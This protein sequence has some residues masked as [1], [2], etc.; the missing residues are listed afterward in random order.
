M[1]DDERAWEV[2][3]RR[4]IACLRS[5]ELVLEAY[6]RRLLDLEEAKGKLMQLG[7]RRWISEEVLEA[8]LKQ[9]KS[10]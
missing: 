2:A 6:R 4:G 3:R 9:L 5:L 1:V 7:K 10:L 8:A